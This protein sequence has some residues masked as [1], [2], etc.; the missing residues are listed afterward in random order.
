MTRK[1]LIALGLLCPACAAPAAKAQPPV[2]FVIESDFGGEAAWVRGHLEASARI[3]VRLMDDPAVE[4]PRKIHVTLEKDPDAG[5]VGGWAGPTALGFVS[6]QWPEEG[7]RL[8]ILTHE[9]INLFAA[10]YA[11][12]GGFP[13]DW[14]SDGRSPFPVYVAGLVLRE[15][16]HADVA[17]DLRSSNAEQPDHELYW[18]LHKRF[19]FGLF[20]RTLRL[21]RE[22]DLDLGEIEPPWPAPSRIRSA[23]TVAYLSLGAGENLTGTVLSHGIGRKPDDWDEVHP[24][25]PFEEYTITPQEVAEIQQARKL[26]FGKAGSEAARALFRAGKWRAAVDLTLSEKQSR[27]AHP[28]SGP[29][30]RAAGARSFPW[31]PGPP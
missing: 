14:W 12:H 3:L 29:A 7:A 17:E 18:A 6:D 13:S 25:I 10:H 30:I 21:L 11:G 4:P 15:L 5:G 23:Y 19:G 27:K 16:G 24:E 1:A 8:W 20:A 31:N 2:R 28:G 26:C 22:D 9:L